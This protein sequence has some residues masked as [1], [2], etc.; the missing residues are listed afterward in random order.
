VPE[1]QKRSETEFGKKGNGDE[2]P[3]EGGLKMVT[4]AVD[5]LYSRKRKGGSMNRVANFLFQKGKGDN[6][7]SRSKFPGQGK[8]AS[9]AIWP[10]R[11]KETKTRKKMCQ[12]DIETIRI[13]KGKQTLKKKGKI[14]LDHG[15]ARTKSFPRIRKNEKRQSA[16]GWGTYGIQANGHTYAKNKP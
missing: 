12:G 7:G 4:N 6:G 11:E 14:G 2:P 9:P 3:K 8:G 5:R 10:K 1:D 15:S 16:M 13:G